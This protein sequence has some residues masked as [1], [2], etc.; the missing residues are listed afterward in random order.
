MVSD[1]DPLVHRRRTCQCYPIYRP[2]SAN[3][4]PAN[5][6]GAT[7]APGKHGHLSYQ[8]FLRPCPSPA[9]LV[10]ALPTLG[11]AFQVGIC[12]CEYKYVWMIRAL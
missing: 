7:A 5:R 1:M 3:P 12:R 9:S 8:D 2:L 10:P 4:E 11:R 6:C